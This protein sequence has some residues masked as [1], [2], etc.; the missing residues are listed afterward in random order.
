MLIKLVQPVGQ[1]THAFVAFGVPATTPDVPALRWFTDPAALRPC[2]PAPESRRAIRFRFTSPPGASA[3]TFLA[4]GPARAWSNDTE[5]GLTLIE[6]F[7]DGS[8]RYHA[9]IKAPTPNSS[10]IT[11]RVEAPRESRGGD[12]LPEPV[13]FDCGAGRIALGDWCE[14]GLATYSGAATYSRTFEISNLKSQIHLDL[15][16]VIAS[17][18]VRVNGHRVAVLVAPPWRANITDFI[19]AGSNEL[20]ITVAN[21]LA[22]HYSVGI[23]TPYAFPS[24]TPSGLFGPVVLIQH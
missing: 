17:A 19:H 8:L 6:S 4:R 10:I 20:S 21:T 16:Q 1:R 11:L 5:C 22:N 9:N 13:R 2:L 7:P 24:Q 12:A 18:E 3:M 14:H 15:G 23:P